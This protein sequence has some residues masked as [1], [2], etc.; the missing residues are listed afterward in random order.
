MR[1]SR[2]VKADDLIPLEPI[3]SAVK[4]SSESQTAA[5]SL[6]TIAKNEP[7]SGSNKVSLKDIDFG[8]DKREEAESSDDEGEIKSEPRD[9]SEREEDDEDED[10]LDT[11]KLK[12]KREDDE[13]LKRLLDEE[14]EELY[15]VLSKTRKKKT[16]ASLAID[17]KT[18][19]NELDENKVDFEKYVDYFFLKPQICIQIKTN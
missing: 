7:E 19:E 15:N 3:K 16:I 5:K 18:E 14:N 2:S 4:S 11:E 9:E 12:A 17:I 1:K 8:L 13:E 6:K 10:F